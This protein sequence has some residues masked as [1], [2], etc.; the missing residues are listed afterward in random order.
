MSNE[1]HERGQLP[2]AYLRIDPNL[3]STH[4][5]PADMIAL[6]C[7]ANRQPKRGLFKSAELAK[8]V[9]GPRLFRRCIERGDL[10]PNGVGLYVDGWEEWQEHDWT[11]GER[12]RRLRGRKRHTDTDGS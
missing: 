10:I 1:P 7:E 6:M 11:V 8:R 4:A 9:L 5:A 3:D 12:M 2:K